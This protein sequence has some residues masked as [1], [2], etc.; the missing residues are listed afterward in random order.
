M[1]WQV[2]CWSGTQISGD[3][4]QGVI[5]NT[6][7]EAGVCAA[8]SNWQAKL[9]PYLPNYDGCQGRFQADLTDFIKLGPAP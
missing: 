2:V 7:V 5:Q 6:V 1:N 3:N 4:A 8:T 9:R